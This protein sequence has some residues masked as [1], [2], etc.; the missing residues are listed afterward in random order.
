MRSKRGVLVACDIPLKQFLR[1]LNQ[2]HK[3]SFIIDEGLDGTHL[4]ITNDVKVQKFLK[5][6]IR[7]WQRSNMYIAR[8]EEDIDDL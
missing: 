4:L 3:P 7:E 5:Q 2:Q 6:K 1:F 8:I